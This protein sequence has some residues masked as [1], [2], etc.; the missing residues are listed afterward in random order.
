MLEK[1]DLNAN[2]QID[3]S[4]AERLIPRQPNW[5]SQSRNLE[6]SDMSSKKNG[7]AYLIPV[8]AFILA[9]TLGN[10]VFSQGKKTSTPPVETEAPTQEE[11]DSLLQIDAS[12]PKD[13]ACPL[14]G[15]LYTQPEKDAWSQ[16]RPLAVMIENTPDARPQ[17]GLSNADIVFEVVA[18]GGITR[19]MP[20]FYCDVQK[21][22]VTL[23]PVR[24]ARTYFINLASGFNYPMYAH[25]GGANFDATPATH[26]LNQLSQYGWVGNNDINQFSVGYPTFV[27]D[28]NR[29]PG[30]EVATE[31]TM[32]TST[33][34]LW[35]VAAKRG[36][37]NMSPDLRIGKKT[38]AAA[39]WQEGYKG[40]QF[41]DGQSKA[42]TQT[43]HYEF[44][45]GFKDYEATWSY[46]ADSNLYTRASGGVAQ[47]DLNNG[48][49]LQFAN[50]IVM[51][52][53]E[54]GP[55]NEV[56][57]MM[58]DVIG[59]GKGLLFS[60]GEA[61]NI[62]WSKK[63]RESELEFTDSKGKS[64]E[65]NRGKIWVSVLSDRNVNKVSY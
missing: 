5:R 25:V 28:Y 49:P 37:T 24:S 64:L 45:S 46:N 57:H 18:E 22:D 48:Q 40:W 34:K 36:W 63:T 9:F 61:Q 44:W 2:N 11:E 51:F 29:I 14:N 13:Q 32:T 20:I 30:K 31:H 12:L 27:R 21:K 52:T 53:K 33:Q 26:S 39:D 10:F 55:L 60:N 35:A 23:A 6:S 3:D 15:Q 54:T 7:F 65:L 38:L 17:S 58:Y 16:K 19:F 4:Q 50:V 1:I 62:T 56:K 42:Q 41:I 47:T 59:Q 43:V 8:L